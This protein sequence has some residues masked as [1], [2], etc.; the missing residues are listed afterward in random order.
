MYFL[1]ELFLIFFNIPF[2]F[3]TKMEIDWPHIRAKMHDDEEAERA[4]SQLLRR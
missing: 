3:Q 4:Q 2:K 1:E